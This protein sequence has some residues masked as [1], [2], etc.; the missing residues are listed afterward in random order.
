MLAQRALAPRELAAAL[1]VLVAQRPPPTT[2]PQP[3]RVS[4]PRATSAPAARLVGVALRAAAPKSSRPS[5]L[6]QLFFASALSTLS[7]VQ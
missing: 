2:L 4:A 5:R 1:P 6:R 7:Q 3:A